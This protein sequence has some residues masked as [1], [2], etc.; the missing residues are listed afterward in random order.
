MKALV[1]TVL[2][3]PFIFIC[4]Q[5]Q[6]VFI[7][8]AKYQSH[9]SRALRYYQ[10]KDFLR[11]ARSYDSLFQQYKGRG[12]RSDRYNAAC[13]W[14]LASNAERAF[15][16]LELV[17]RD[18]KWENL[19]HLLG[20]RDLVSLHE[21]ARW[22][23]IIERVKANREF[24]ERNLD[25]ALVAL[26]DTV[27]VR[28]QTL[29]LGADSVLKKFGAQSEEVRNYWQQIQYQ[30]SINLLVVKNIIDT[31]GWPGPDLVGAQGAKT[32]FLVI[33]H[34][35]ST[36]HANYLPL[37]RE[38]AKKKKA[39]V[40]DLAMLEDRLLTEQGKEQIYGSQLR[41]NDSTNSYELFP[42][43]DEAGVNERRAAIGLPPIEEYVRFFGIEYKK[44]K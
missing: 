24:A 3:M 31:R 37:L 23:I 13:S 34:A 1:L 2:V 12:L 14:A 4:A 22:N 25:K 6:D 32:I 7:P 33:Q 21:D 35:D 44:P 8:D 10:D 43:K 36:T 20:D 39:S 40:Q 15:Y 26:L 27:H 11:S 9:A 42:I 19:A 16:Y 18:D 29:R 17:A 41:W 30:D 28:D 38:A 5:A